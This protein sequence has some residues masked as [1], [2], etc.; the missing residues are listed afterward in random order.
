M[1][2]RPSVRVTVSSPSGVT[3]AVVASVVTVSSLAAPSGSSSLSRTG[4]VTSVLPR[5]SS[6]GTVSSRATGGSRGAFAETFTVT[7]PVARA[8]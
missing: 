5:M 8:P 6:T 3:L 2:W 1:T 7:A 4:T